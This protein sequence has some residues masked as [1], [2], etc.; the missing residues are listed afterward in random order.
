LVLMVEA[1][2]ELLKNLNQRRR[3]L[4]CLLTRRQSVTMDEF[5]RSPPRA[6]AQ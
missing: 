2:A 6:F 5:W 1:I 4:Q 3:R